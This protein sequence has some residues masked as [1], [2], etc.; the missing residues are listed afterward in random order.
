MAGMADMILAHAKSKMG[1]M[2]SGDEEADEPAPAS[3]SGEDMGLESAM[4]ELIQAFAA[5]DKTAAAKAFHSAFTICS[6]MH[7]A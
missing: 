6:S 1:K 2:G 5:S 3:E 7:D 4:E